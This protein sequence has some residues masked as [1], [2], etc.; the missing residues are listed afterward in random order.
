[1]RSSRILE[2]GRWKNPAGQ[3]RPKRGRSV[4]DS[5]ARL[6]DRFPETSV[7][8]EVLECDGGAELPLSAKPET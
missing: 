1:M 5:T 4:P 8:R 2:G 6:R 3:K 7:L